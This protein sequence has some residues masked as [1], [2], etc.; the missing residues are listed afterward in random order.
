[1][2]GFTPINPRPMLQALVD[3]DVIIR[4]KWGQEYHGKLISV[5]SYM[6]IQMRGADEWIDGKSTGNLGEVLIRCN[7][8]LWISALDA[9]GKEV[10]MSG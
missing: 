10:E 4:L 5:D 6:N 1:M 2:S 8:V 7:N 9:A 3:K